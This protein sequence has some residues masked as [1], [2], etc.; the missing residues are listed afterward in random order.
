MKQRGQEETETPQ[1][2]GFARK[3]MQAL[4]SKIE[5][6]IAIAIAEHETRCH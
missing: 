5:R 6:K 3:A 4:L 1:Y 2:L